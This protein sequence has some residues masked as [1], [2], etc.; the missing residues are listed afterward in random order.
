MICHASCPSLSVV[1][2]LSESWRASTNAVGRYT[3]VT[4][5]LQ[6]DE[7]AVGTVQSGSARDRAFW[8]DGWYRFTGAAGDR[9]ADSA[10]RPYGCGTDYGGWV[11]CAPL[12]T[13]EPPAP[14]R[15]NNGL[16]HTAYRR[17]SLVWWYVYSSPRPTR[18]LARRLHRAPYV[19]VPRWPHRGGSIRSALG[20]SRSQC[21]RA[22]MRQGIQSHTSTSYK[23]RRRARTE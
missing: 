3:D 11:R 12:C 8:R 1:S 5:D 15:Q 23:A 21:A 16:R 4:G 6:S 19:S 9:M 20:R 7:P 18:R 2:E 17:V 10:P 14:A 13:L 22:Y